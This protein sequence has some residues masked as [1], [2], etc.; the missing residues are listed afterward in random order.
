MPKKP[1]NPSSGTSN[2]R[3]K[4]VPKRGSSRTSSKKKKLT[5]IPLGGM[6]EIGKNMTL[7]GYG[8]DYII[9]DC[10][11]TF[12]DEE[13]P[14]VDIIIPDFTFLRSIAGQIRGL[15]LTH[16]HEDHIGAVAY[17]LREFGCPVYGTPLTIK[18]VENKLTDGGRGG[19]KVIDSDPRLHVVS[20]GD[21][22]KAG[23]FSVEFIHVN[24]SIAD[25]CA[26]ALKTPVGTLVHTGDFK[27]D[28]TPVHGDPI[29]LNRFAQLGSE[30]VLA[31]F[32][33]STNVEIPGMTPSEQR[34]ENS[35]RE[36]FD[37]AKGRIFVATFSSNVFRL[38]QIITVAEEYHRKV[39]LLGYSMQKIF[40]AANSLSYLHYKPDTLIEAWD[41]ERYPDNELLYIATGTQGEPMSA[42]T[43]IAFSEHKQVNI[44][45]GDTVLLSSSFIPGNEKSIYKVINELFKRGARVIYEKLAD[46]HVSGHAYQDEL[47]LMI[48]LVHPRYFIPAH[49]EF[50]H[51]YKNAELAQ[52]QGIP[53]DRIFLL[54]NGDQLELDESQ[55]AITGYIEQPGVLIDGSGDVDS[56]VLA[57]RRLL[58]DDGVVTCFLVVDRKR[59]TLAAPPAI[60]AV[61]FIYA[62]DMEKITNQCRRR[63]DGFVERIQ[64]QKK[65]LAQNLKHAQFRDQLQSELYQNTKRRPIIVVSVVEI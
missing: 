30:G 24:H 65:R 4:P 37:D 19:R 3:T 12:P 35:F 62:E 42:L 27:V 7:F 18:L 25:A 44:K 57:E 29:D 39:V 26:L 58:A 59:N 45:E 16:G 38:Q 36:Y 50:R 63:I 60:E 20:T 53:A 15:F 8:D 46:I 34:V 6:R 51:L 40:E 56:Q 52:S 61:G 48:D 41:A 47:R 28:F 43:R 23:A 64:S 49:G 11:T 9:V 13:A 1:E 14:G 55:G 54:S 21:Q 5:V 31:L 33:E 10:G 2:R 32:M 22:I 17:F